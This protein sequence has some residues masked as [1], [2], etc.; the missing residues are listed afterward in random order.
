MI[1]IL[2]V[3]AE[4]FS[5]I[6]CSLELYRNITGNIYVVGQTVLKTKMVP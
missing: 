5:F 6:N 4:Q 1:A 2:K 3:T